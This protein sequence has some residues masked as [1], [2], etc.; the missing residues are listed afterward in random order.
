M[1][2]E[3][4]APIDEG[5]AAL[6]LLDEEPEEMRLVRVVQL[7]DAAFGDDAAVVCLFPIR[8]SDVGGG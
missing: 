3:V 7:L 8:I 1:Q 4:I 6:E 5:C 2:P